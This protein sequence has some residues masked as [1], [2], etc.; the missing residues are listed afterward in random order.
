[1]EQGERPDLGKHPGKGRRLD[2][3]VPQV[4][5]SAVAAVVAAKL[6]S[7]LGVYG[8]IM[9]AGVVS[10]LGTCGGSLLQHVFHRT[11]RHVHE[12]AGH[13]HGAATQV[14]PKILRS[15]IETAATATRPAADTG[16][17]AARTFT[18]VEPPRPP[19]PRR[20]VP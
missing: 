14:K 15:A 6:A 2:L 12:V 16:T 7:N 17:A 9:G 18:A 4:A 11:G 1:M 8:T 5:G 13:V 20:S 10:V 19:L 3:S